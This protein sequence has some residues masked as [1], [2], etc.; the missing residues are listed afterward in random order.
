MFVLQ[1]FGDGGL[2]ESAA[3]LATIAGTVVLVGLLIA[4]GAF[5]YKS[6]RGGGIRWP[7]DE[8][9]TGSEGG[10][11]RNSDDDEWKYS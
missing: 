10:V 7:D 8:E 3:Q 6:T 11:T 1:A 4:F 2:I 5:V 9:S